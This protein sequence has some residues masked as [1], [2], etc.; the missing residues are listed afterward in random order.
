M[1]D[2]SR[3]SGIYS[4]FDVAGKVVLVTGGAQGIGRMIAEGFVRAGAKV[5]F[6]SRKPEI[7]EAA[8]AEMARLGTC[9]GIPA[10]LA[11]PQAATALAAQLRER[12]A[13]LHVLVN[14]AGRTWGAPL[15][16]FPDN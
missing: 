11:T 8:Q 4:V 1:T 6:T 13:V 16:D 10:D 14:N 2:V 3:P 5:Y 9:I 12:E 15:Q 7:C